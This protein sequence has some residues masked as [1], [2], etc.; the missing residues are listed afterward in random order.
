[1]VVTTAFP[2]PLVIVVDAKHMFLAKRSSVTSAFA[3]FTM[4]SLSPVSSAS[5]ANTWS[6]IWLQIFAN[7]KVKMQKSSKVPKYRIQ[8]KYQNM[9]VFC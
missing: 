8:P 6:A 2:R 5:F 1:M 4:S 7:F 3:C 9:T